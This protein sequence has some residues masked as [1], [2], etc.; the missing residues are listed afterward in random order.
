M[1]LTKIKGAGVNISATEKL[2]FDDGGNTYIYESAADVLDVYVGGANMVK[3]TESTTDT[4]TVTGDLT[5]GVDGTGHDV[6]F[7]GDTGSAYMLWDQS[8]DDLVLA[9]AAGIDLAGDIDV[10]GTANLDVVDIDG[11]VDMASTLQI[12]GTVTVSA[13]G[14][15]A[16]VTIHSNTANEGLLYDASEDEL[17]LL[18]TTKLKFHDIGGGEEIYAS[19]N[20]H[21]EINSGTTLDITAPT[22]DINA[23]T[24]VTVDGN[25]LMETDKKIYQKGAFLQSSTHQALTL[26][27]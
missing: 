7:F 19:A 9:G 17:G 24:A 15:G 16:D 1:A 10:D 5:V 11:A 18:L 2:Y 27:Y 4:V 13:S 12:D 22:V 26:G 3:L 6:K 25:V 14:T 21:L 23:S 8:A 20:G